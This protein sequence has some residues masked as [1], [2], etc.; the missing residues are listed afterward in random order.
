MRLVNDASS[1]T[2]TV[3]SITRSGITATAIA[4]GATAIGLT[5]ATTVTGALTATGTLTAATNTLV[6]TGGLAAVSGALTVS[7]NLTVSGTITGSLA[8][9]TV[10]NA[11]MANMTASTV[12]GQIVGGSGAPVDLT[13]AQLAA[14]GAAGGL[15]AVNNRQGGSASDWGTSG[16]TNYTPATSR[17][18]IG[19]TL[20]DGSG[21]ATVTFPAAFSGTPVVTTG[22]I[23][24]AGV[25][26][27]AVEIVTLNTTTVAFNSSVIGATVLWIAIGPP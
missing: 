8:A 6:V 13:A 19:T 21:V 20:T 16:T 1:S 10:T 18:Q 3:L 27:S 17:V 5:G 22:V 24:A 12:K 15:L 14:I 9:A 2:T 4:M 7:T 25:P 26:T 23:G 11:M